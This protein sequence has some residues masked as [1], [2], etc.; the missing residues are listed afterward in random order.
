ML[1]F[2]LGALLIL[3]NLL[4]ALHVGTPTWVS[5]GALAA[6]LI[7]FAIGLVK[8][9]PRWSLPYG[10]VIG[11]NVDWILTRRGTFIGLNTRAGVLGP[12]LGWLDRLLLGVLG[13]STP[14]FIRAVF[15]AGLDWVAL[16]GL[17]ACGL[18]IVAPWRPLRPLYSRIREDWTQLSFALYGATMLAVFY[19]FEDYPTAKCSSMSVSS[20]ILA[21]GA[22]F[23][24]H[25]GRPSRQA[26]P[27]SGPWRWWA[28]WC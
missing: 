4:D 5:G 10:G 16:L 14:W 25:N 27:S 2:S 11:L 17:T 3:L 15:G 21:A 9:L 28:R 6:V 18:L 22:W 7:P 20:L 24:V 26:V 1:P 12:L 13:P 8:G 23:Y 19:A